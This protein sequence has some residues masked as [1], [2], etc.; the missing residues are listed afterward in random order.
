MSTLVLIYVFILIR[1]NLV[2]LFPIRNLFCPFGPIQSI[3]VHFDRFK[4]LQSILALFGPF[5]AYGILLTSMV[6]AIFFSFHLKI[7]F[8]VFY[9]V[10]KLTELNV[11]VVFYLSFSGLKLPTLNYHNDQ[12]LVI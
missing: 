3:C 1:S 6:I 11:L 2:H 4:P 8:L 7:H 12:L 10:A 5:N 9:F